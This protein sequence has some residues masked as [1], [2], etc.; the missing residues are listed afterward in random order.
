M[1][2]VI[3]AACKVSVQKSYPEPHEALTKPTERNS[4]P[5]HDAATVRLR[6]APHD[7]SVGKRGEAEQWH[8]LLRIWTCNIQRDK[9]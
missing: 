2:Q 6:N 1:V 7:I 4:P 3:A 9:T 5:T 8:V